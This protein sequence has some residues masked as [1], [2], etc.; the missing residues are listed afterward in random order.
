MDT[1]RISLQGRNTDEQHN[2]KCSTSFASKKMQFKTT[3]KI[4]TEEETQR[5]SLV[6]WFHVHWLVGLIF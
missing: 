5:F 4:E 1:L 6:H 3:L 2:F